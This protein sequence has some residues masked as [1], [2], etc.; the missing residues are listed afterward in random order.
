[1]SQFGEFSNFCR[2]ST[3][4]VCNLFLYGINVPAKSCGL[5]GF[6]AG[7]NQ[8]GN[9]GSVV[10]AGIAIIVSG[11]LLWMA[12]R[13]AA[14]VGRREMQIL[15]LGYILVSFAEIF[16]VG[17]FLTSQSAL[18]W[19]TGIHIGAITATFWV[20]LLNAIVGY[21]LLDDGTILSIL[22]VGGSMVVVFIGTG[23]IAMD[24]ALGWTDTFVTLKSEGYRNYALYVLYLLFPIISV[25]AY[26]ILESV[27]V[28]KVFDFVISVHLC[29]ATSGKI[30]GSLFQT[31]FTLL[32]VVT[33]W[34]FWSSITEDVWID[35]PL[36]P[37]EETTYGP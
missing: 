21:Q 20:L 26:F 13:K 7:G 10:L 24:T 2:D 1:M 29:N 36:N 34:Y 32:S 8:V 9:L 23:Y 3:I 5:V 22:L 37:M 15:L 31:L 25:A 6:T 19:F 17:E 11:V 16:T 4:P 30:D 28:L 33:L 18:K 27:L 12:E 35:E 14:A